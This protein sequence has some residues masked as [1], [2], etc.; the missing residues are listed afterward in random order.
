MKSPV[1]REMT[2]LMTKIRRLASTAVNKRLSLV[3]SSMHE[4]RVLFRLAHDERVPQ[5]ELAFDAAMDR[6]AASRLLRQMTQVGLVTA[7]VDSADK[8]QRMVRLTHK[9]RTLER[10]LSPIVDQALLPYMGGLT[11]AEDRQFLSLLRK[12]CAACVTAARAEEE[13]EQ[14]RAKA[15]PRTISAQP[16]RSKRA[17]ATAPDRIPKSKSR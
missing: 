9:G 10:T 12:A 2:L 15:S 13:E 1:H 4:Y 14:V 7:E 6:A 5:H 11:A 3:G 16:K 17:P 8:R